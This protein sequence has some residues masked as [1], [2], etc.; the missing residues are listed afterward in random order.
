[1]KK[2]AGVL[3]REGAKV[4]MVRQS[5]GAVRHR[6]LWGPPGGGVEEGE[7]FEK[8][9]VREVKEE[10]GLRVELGRVVWRGMMTDKSGKKMRLKIFEARRIAGVLEVENDEYVDEVRWV[11]REEIEKDRLPLR[12]KVLKEMLLDWWDRKSIRVKE[13][14]LE[15][16][17]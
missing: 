15:V 4:L 14:R 9:A 11:S 6:G 10:T 8:A 5:Q 1:M 12:E 13:I 7:T 3:M 17:V 2:W 16:E